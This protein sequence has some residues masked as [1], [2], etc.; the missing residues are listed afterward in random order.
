MNRRCI[1]PASGFYEWDPYK[2]RF[3]FADP[4]DELLLLAGL[5]HEE[6]GKPHYAILTTQANESMQ[7][8]HDRMP[9]MI[10]RD[11]MIPWL[12]DNE[13][14]SDFL[15]RPQVKLVR[16]QDSGQMRMDFGL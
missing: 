12:N 1:I 4:K 15:E 6:Q 14:L 9:V 8:I 3:R 10:S 2:A 7:P 11:E 13:K 16:E 5:Y